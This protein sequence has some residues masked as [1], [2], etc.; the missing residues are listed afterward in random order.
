VSLES[1]EEAKR[2]K[3]VT[4][5]E[6]KLKIIADF[7]YGILAANIVHGHRI[8]PTAVSTVVANKQKKY[9]GVKKNQQCLEQVIENQRL[10]WKWIS[11][12]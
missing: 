3:V 4:T 10:C 11:Y 8:V 2:P 7:E 12:Y 1:D 5:L 6:M 9:K